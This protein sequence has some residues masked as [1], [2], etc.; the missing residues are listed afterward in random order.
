ML[1][2]ASRQAQRHRIGDIN[3]MEIPRM[4]PRRLLPASLIVL[5]VL[6]GAS[7]QA[8]PAHGQ[9]FGKPAQAAQASRSIEVVLGDMYFKPRAI[10]VKAGETVRFVLKNEGKLLHEFNLGDAA[11]HAEHQ[12]EMLE[13]QQSGML[14]PTGMASMDHSQMGHGMAGMDHGR[15]MKHDDPNSVLVEPGKSAE[16]T[17][18]FAKATRLE[19]ACNIPGHYQAGMVGQLTVQP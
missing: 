18:T 19:F 1:L 16:L 7:A 17:W 2:T 12:K 3:P 5:G 6:F 9:A 8:S 11:M 10:E 4:F 14:T 15:M 13:M